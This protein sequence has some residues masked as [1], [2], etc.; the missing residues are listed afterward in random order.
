MTPEAF[1]AALKRSVDNCAISDADYLADPP[2]QS[3]PEHFARFS[4]WFRKLSADDQEVACE[5]I[6]YSAGG[7]LYLLLTYLDNVCSLPGQKVSSSCGMLTRVE[8]EGGST[9]LMGV[10]STSFTTIL[11][12]QFPAPAAL[13]HRRVFEPRG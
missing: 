2:S 7:S 5:L 4:A 13:R 6:R 11:S 12:S 1:V 10:Y 9:I 3:P 8:S